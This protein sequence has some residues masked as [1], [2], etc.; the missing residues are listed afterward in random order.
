MRLARVVMDI[1]FAWCRQ[2]HRRAWRK[3]IFIDGPHMWASE[4]SKCR[5]V[6]RVSPPDN[7]DEWL[8]RMTALKMKS[9]TAVK[10]EDRN[11]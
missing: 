11:P 8:A 4:C 7:R 1:R 3:P 10:H 6:H 5:C 2:F 9:M